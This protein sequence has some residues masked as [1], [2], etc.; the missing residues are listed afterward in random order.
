M[1]GMNML[2]RVMGEGRKKYGMRRFLQRKIHQRL[3]R[4]FHRVTKKMLLDKLRSVGLT[5]GST[6]MVHASVSHLGYVEGGPEA[7][8][9]AL[10]ELVGP[11]G[12]VM[13]PA[14][15]GRGSMLDWLESGEVFDV[16]YTPSE[17]GLLPETFRK[18]PGVLRS[19]HP[20]NSV[21]GWGRNAKELLQDHHKSHT[22][23]GTKTPFGRMAE[24]DDACIL[25]IDTYI[26]SL[27]HHLQE[28]VDYPNLFL[29]GDKTVGFIDEQGQ[30]GSMITRV[31]RP[32]V[33]YY[34]AIPAPVGDEPSWVF[35]GDFALL[36][37]T[38][39]AREARIM[40]YSFDGYPPILQRRRIFTESRVFSASKI[41]RAEI[42]LL[43]VRRFLD[44]VEPE[45]KCLLQRFNHHYDVQK[46]TNLK[47]PPPS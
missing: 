30:L 26:R 22:P 37:P 5:E 3:D 39:R 19:I 40:G 33:P 47:L 29:P 1:R 38:N 25:L 27:L 36:F 7:I 35:L 42:G 2:F 44:A 23:F 13:M 28:R 32:V 20:T 9:D 31:L 45:L 4:T 11:R 12:C 17:S 16:R 34:L 46:I 18:R 6:V 14:F 10:L 8:I 24:K 15:S 21:L 43:H 41:G